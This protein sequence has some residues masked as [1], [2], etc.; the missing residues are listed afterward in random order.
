M[1]R[2]SL[3]GGA[4]RW[5]ACWALLAAFGPPAQ[6]PAASVRQTESEL[7]SIREQ[8]EKISRESATMPWSAIS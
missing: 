1:A 3:Y 8:I 6:A 5:L 4:R 7:K 2:F